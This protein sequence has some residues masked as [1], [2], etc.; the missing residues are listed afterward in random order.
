MKKD[1]PKDYCPVC[2]FK[3][4]HWVTDPDQD[5]PHA[6]HEDEYICIHNPVMVRYQHRNGDF[7]E[8]GKHHYNHHTNDL[9]TKVTIVIGPFSIK[10]NLTKEITTINNVDDG[11]ILL[12]TPLWKDINYSDPGS[13]IDYAK[14][15]LVFS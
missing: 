13:V 15:L 14:K 4:E 5:H 8:F 1:Y 6:Y 7:V 12:T 2:Q 11:K 10:H 9:R 3:L